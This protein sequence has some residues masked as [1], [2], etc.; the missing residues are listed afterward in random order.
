MIRL[1]SSSAIALGVNMRNIDERTDPVSKETRCRLWCSIFVLEQFLTTITGRPTSLDKAFAVNAPLPFAESSFTDLR[2][3]QLLTGD[4]ER[5]KV[6]N[7]TLFEDASQTLTRSVQLKSVQ[8][9]PSLYFFYQVDLS[10]IANAITSRL[11]GARAPQDGWRPVKEAIV[12]YSQKLD[13]WM[14][15][16]NEEMSFAD[17][18]GQLLHSI[19]SQNQVGLAL[20]FYSTRILLNRPC[21]SRP[22]FRAR[23]G[24]RFPRNRF[25][26]DTALACVHSAL[27][28]LDVLPD[29]ASEDWF[30][31]TSPWWTML[32]FLMQATTVLLIQLAVGTVPVKTEQ[33]I[34]ESVRAASSDAV[35]WSCKKALHW[36]HHMARKDQACRRG[37]ELCHSLFCRIAL[38]KDLNREDIPSPSSLQSPDHPDPNTFYRLSRLQPFSESSA[39]P[40]LGSAH[41]EGIG[42]GAP[43]TTAAS[44]IS[45]ENRPSELFPLGLMEDPEFAW[46]LSVADLDPD[47]ATHSH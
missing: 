21:L 27:S 30:Y 22:G 28:L 29:E 45:M 1:A 43:T 8:S 41:E 26:N 13:T 17:S 10:L 39:E 42:S 2:V 4:V 31:R 20:N 5:A 15:T 40:F 12:S 34:E 25:G 9:S 3:S 37:F 11:Y 19:L 32:H 46:F 36:L 18:N 35:L 33:G 47:P 23:S 7:W 24:I 38:S 44:D 16:I 6:V 14:S